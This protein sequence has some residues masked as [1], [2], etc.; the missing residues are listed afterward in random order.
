MS[1][2]VWLYFV[3]TIGLTLIVLLAWW[4]YSRIQNTAILQYLEVKRTYPERNEPGRNQAAEMC[5]G[6]VDAQLTASLEVESS[7]NSDNMWL[8]RKASIGGSADV[9]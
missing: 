7:F 6:G 2:W 1:S 4:Y 8:H 9:G 3:V 5:E